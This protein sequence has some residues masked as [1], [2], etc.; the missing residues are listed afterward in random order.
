M[1]TIFSHRPLAGVSVGAYSTNGT[2]FVAFALV[3]DG[4]S[5]RGFFHEDH[6]DSF[7]RKE[8]RSHV[9]SRIRSALNGNSNRPLVMSFETDMND[10]DFMKVF[11][12][13][14]KPTVDES[15]DFLSEIGQF[16]GVEVRTRAD[17]IVERL[18]QAVNGVIVNAST[19]I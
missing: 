11:R 18:T 6:E 15:D 5:R 12:Q 1:D 9:N 19:S 17:D 13:T 10:R 16:A 8:A 3:N 2:L 7:S 14:F 4:I